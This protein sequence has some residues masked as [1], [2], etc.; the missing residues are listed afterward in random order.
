MTQE[1]H[2][3]SDSQLEEIQLDDL[4]DIQL[5]VLQCESEEEIA[6]ES[7]LIARLP[8]MNESGECV[9]PLTAFDRA[10]GKPAE[11][12]TD[13][14]TFLI[15]QPETSSLP[16]SFVASDESSLTS[17]PRP[18]LKYKRTCSCSPTPD[19]VIEMS[20]LVS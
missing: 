3:T 11:Q 10:V 12:D 18:Y 7:H 15:L 14:G 16:Q 19:M 9:R 13:F 17:A 5:N 20:M 1:A 2:N 8:F 4:G 6:N